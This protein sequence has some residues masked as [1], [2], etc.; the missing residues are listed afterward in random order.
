MSTNR[1][2][3]KKTKRRSRSHPVAVLFFVVLVCALGFLVYQNY[4]AADADISNLPSVEGDRETPNLTASPNDTSPPQDPQDPQEPT[5]P[6]VDVLPEYNPYSVGSTDPYNLLIGTGQMVNGTVVD[7]HTLAEPIDFGYAA[8][9]TQLQ[10]ITTFRGNNFRDS[11]AYGTLDIAAGKLDKN[12]WNIGTGSLTAPNGAYWSGS[13]WTGQ[14]LIVKWPKETRA[15]MTN[16]YDWAKD[17][18][19]LVEVIYPTMDG[20]IYFMELES[21]S[22]T[23]DNLLM[24]Y[25]FKGTGSIDPRGY[26]ILYVGAG[27]HSSRGNAR[28]FAISLIDGSIL[29]EF[30]NNDP[31]SL[32]GTLSYF[33]SAPLIDA[34]TDQLIYPGESGILYIIKLNT[35]Y[36]EAAG[37]LTMNPSDVIKWRYN[38]KRTTGASYWLGMEASAIIWRGHIIMSDNG[39]NFMCLN[40]NTL[41]I[42]WVQDVLDDSNSTP[43][44][45]IEDGHPYLYV[46]TSFHL[47]WRSS[48]TAD[49]PIWKIDALSGEI[50]WRTDFTCYSW[51]E[52]SGGTQASPAIG[53]NGLADLIFYPV[54]R[55]P[56]IGNGKIVA[57]DKKTGDIVWEH[58]T[59]GYSWSSPVAVYDKTGKG[60][61]VFGTSS[62]HLYFIDGLTGEI[63]DNI[64]LGSNIEAS[65][66]V[67]NNTIVIGTREAGIYGIKIT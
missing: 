4:S 15:N 54:A 60:Y 13:G 42:V 12:P 18:D 65:P 36:D 20:N 5:E 59:Q 11:A 30:G 27:Y 38:G 61:L 43:V 45:E 24:G 53:K 41:E 22:K 6:P 23:R 8:D 25:T 35:N 67:Y 57:L 62:G 63:L 46:S 19:E 26:P 56:N 31:Y 34:E 33:D 7:S 58:T 66:A 17:K 32:R 14:P 39:G 1:G 21:G 9:Y 49:V 64:N 2:Y 37:S 48:G 3:G 16:M 10:G 40:L 28:A 51:A 44:L 55:T 29:Y 47:G 50:V 52:V